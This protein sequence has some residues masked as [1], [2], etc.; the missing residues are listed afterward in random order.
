MPANNRYKLQVR[1]GDD[2]L[3]AGFTAVPNLFLN[4][5]RDLGISDGAALWIVHLLKFRWTEDNPY[6]RRSSIPMNA[7]KDTQKRYARQL[8]NLGLLFTK[9]IYWSKEDAPPNP[10][11]VGTIRALEYDLTS[12]FH[13]LVRISR[14]RSE[15]RPLDDFEIEIPPEIVEKVASGHFHHVPKKWQRL[16]EEY[17]VTTGDGTEELE[18]ENRTVEQETGLQG[19]NRTAVLES[20]N[21]PLAAGGLEGE[22]RTV[23][24]GGDFQPVEN[25]PHSNKDT[26]SNKIHQIPEKDEQQQNT[27]P[28][29]ADVVVPIDELKDVQL[30]DDQVIVN[31]DGNNS[32]LVVTSIADAVRSELRR[33]HSDPF[34]EAEIYY[35]VDHALGEGPDDWTDEE[36]A[37]IRCKQALERKL[38]E[39]YARL[40]AFALDEALQQ[41][42]SPQ[43]TIEVLKDKPA[44]ELER[45]E[46]W[47]AYVRQQKNLTNPAGFLRTSIQSGEMPPSSGARTTDDG[48]PLS[49]SSVAGRDVPSLTRRRRGL[50][51]GVPSGDLPKDQ[52]PGP[53]QDPEALDPEIPGVGM[54]PR[55]L[56]ETALDELQLQMPRATFDAWLKNTSIARVENNH[57][58]VAVR[59]SQAVDWLEHRLN[60]KVCQTLAGILGRPVMVE[61]EVA[62]AAKDHENNRKTIRTAVR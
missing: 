14:W 24:L 35:S 23:V 19:E 46:D 58:V 5:Y 62:M 9:R 44:S 6:P 50:V 39:R 21:H 54:T 1:F 4:N 18:G 11:L 42:F 34:Y 30:H 47:V 48:L 2:L 36:L 57:L 43:F 33:R 17:V 37:R 40:G 56:W 60:P 38:G 32:H 61:Y 28:P 10:H 59:N 41:Y 16:C 52:K 15:G 29:S 7:N 20:E 51:E 49:S 13:N 26:S 27:W 3:E 8:R 22:N 53:V 45:I 25:H 12:L 55:D 31:Y